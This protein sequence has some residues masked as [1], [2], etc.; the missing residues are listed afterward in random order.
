MCGFTRNQ[1][2]TAEL[3]L[4]LTLLQVP[5]FQHAIETDWCVSPK[6]ICCNLNLSVILSGS[7]S[8]RRWVGHEGGDLMNGISVLILIKE[9]PESSLPTFAMWGH[10]KKKTVSEP[11]SRLSPDTES[12]GTMNLD[13]PA[14]KTVKNKF[15]FLISHPDYNILLWQPRWTKAQNLFK[16]LGYT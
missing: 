6:L 15:L 13:I 12:P 3:F 10:S 14:S 8:F 11:G 2:H 9:A 16:N 5:R 1:N 7:G 4:G